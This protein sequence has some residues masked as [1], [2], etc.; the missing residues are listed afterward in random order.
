MQNAPLVAFCNTFDLHLA[1]FGIENQFYVILIVAVLHKCYCSDCLKIKLIN[2]ALQC[3]PGGH[4]LVLGEGIY[5]M[6]KN[7][8]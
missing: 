5:H 4:C 7:E 8:V 3:V 6:V 2:M 1:I